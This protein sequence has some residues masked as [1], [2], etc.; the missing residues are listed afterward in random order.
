MLGGAYFATM[1]KLH[2]ARSFAELADL[3][4]A[5]IPAVLGGGGLVVVDLDAAGD[6]RGVVGGGGFAEHL[7]RRIGCHDGFSDAGIDLS[8]LGG[9]VVAAS[10]ALG[11]AA[12]RIGGGVTR[13]FSAEVPS[14]TLVGEMVS[15]AFRRGILCAYL[16]AGNFQDSELRERFEAVLLNLR[17]IMERIACK[18]A[19][20]KVVQ[21]V[22]SFRPKQTLALFSINRAAEVIPLSQAAVAFS[23]RRWHRDEPM[24]TLD[25]TARERVA[26]ASREAWGNP[27]EPLWG[28]V[29]LNLGR[30]PEWMDLLPKLCGEAVLVMHPGDTPQGAAAPKILTNRQGEI[31]GWIAEGKTSAE[32]GIILGISPRTVEKHLEAIFQRMGVENRIAA[33]RSYMEMNERTSQH[34]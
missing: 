25:G 15:G 1:R 6:I 19:E 14:D 22:L 27:I 16:E 28:S 17:A 34:H 23:E 12:Y 7:R 5:Q 10:D 18:D 9:A 20:A 32:V 21:K 13:I 30:G 11:P 4:V 29:E 2:E 31:M 26:S 33:V 8:Q 3:I 24:W